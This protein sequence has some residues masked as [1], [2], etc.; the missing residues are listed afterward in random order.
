VSITLNGVEISELRTDENSVL[1][2]RVGK[3]GDAD[4]C[5]N[6]L[7]ELGLCGKVLV[8]PHDWEIRPLTAEEK[9]RLLSDETQ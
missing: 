8:V 1:L 4:H 5:L 3:G 6:A 2:L 7:R 9:A